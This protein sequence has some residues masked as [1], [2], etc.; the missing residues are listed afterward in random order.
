MYVVPSVCGDAAAYRDAGTLAIQIAPVA[1]GAMTQ[2]FL[3]LPLMGRV[4][5][6]AGRVG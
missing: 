2:F 4:D 3:S 6:E 1:R 5:G